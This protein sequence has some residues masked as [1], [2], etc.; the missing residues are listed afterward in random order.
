MRR[1]LLAATA[2]S[3]LLAL[4]PRGSGALG[5]ARIP[6]NPF[7]AY[8][9]NVDVIRADL[10]CVNGVIDSVVALFGRP[11]GACPSFAPNPQCDLAGFGAYAEAACLGQRN[12]TLTSRQDQD[13]CFGALKA[14]AA[15]A[16]CSEGPGGYAPASTPSVGATYYMLQP[17]INGSVQPFGL[18]HCTGIASF[19]AN[20]DG[21]D[22][23]WR[24]TEGQDDDIVGISL[25]PNNYFFDSLGWLG[26][27][28]VD[29]Y[30]ATN[31]TLG[32]VS[33]SGVGGL[34]VPLPDMSWW[35]VEGLDNSGLGFSL[36]THSKSSAVGGFVLT[37][38]DCTF[39]PFCYKGAAF[40]L[41]DAV[42]APAGATVAG[43]G[44]VLS[45]TFAFVPIAQ[46]L[47]AG[48]P[49]ST[50]HANAQ[51][52]GN[53]QGDGPG[54]TYSTCRQQMLKTD[55][56]AAAAPRFLSSG[57]T[58]VQDSWWLGGSSDDSLWLLE[59]LAVAQQKKKHEQ[60]DQEVHAQA[61][62]IA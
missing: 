36:K 2:A 60:H 61:Q 24:V 15:V 21:G 32:I 42:L 9:S 49:W 33:A 13:P 53:N 27:P 12:C 5:A 4:A 62:G 52:T 44:T 59:D 8:E 55:P 22:F 28:P 58:S 57:V 18:R 11:S 43:N 48:A 41:G 51:N 25:Q 16:H 14:I 45:Q 3:I 1:P 17:V 23:E 31:L 19:D 37:V 29:S 50:D 10:V 39:C 7:C 56:L 30:A 40:H 47:G 26:Q 35:L 20:P 6:T 46:K 34:R 38:T 54:E